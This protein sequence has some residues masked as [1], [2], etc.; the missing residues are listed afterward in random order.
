MVEV[1]LGKMHTV[2]DS[3]VSGFV[4]IDVNANA[5]RIMITMM[6]TARKEYNFLLFKI[7]LNS[8]LRTISV[9]AEMSRE[10]QEDDR[11]FCESCKRVTVVPCLI[12]V[13]RAVITCNPKFK[14]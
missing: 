5:T 2:S 12:A 6:T 4:E 9:R 13:S 8:I 11:R 10:R 1:V 7:L 14:C 3:S